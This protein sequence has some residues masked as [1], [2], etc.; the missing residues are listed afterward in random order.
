M[1]MEA[2]SGAAAVGTMREL[3]DTLSRIDAPPVPSK[4]ET[5]IEQSAPSRSSSSAMSPNHQ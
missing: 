1:P 3:P 5:P 2:P 4:R